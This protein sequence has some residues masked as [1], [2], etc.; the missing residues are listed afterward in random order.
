MLNDASYFKGLYWAESP[1]DSN[2]TTDQYY[3]PADYIPRH[4]DRLC[5]RAQSAGKDFMFLTF[6]HYPC[7]NGCSSKP[8]KRWIAAFHSAGPQEPVWGLVAI[9]A[10]RT[11]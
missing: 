3:G 4:A 2:Q 1:Q 10:A 9:P 6:S 5:A 8:F 11:T 7:R